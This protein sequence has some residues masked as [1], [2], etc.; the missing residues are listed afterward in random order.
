M[1]PLFPDQKKQW[2]DESPLAQNISAILVKHPEYYDEIR[3][4]MGAIFPRP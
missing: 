3:A 2:A 4:H 1:E